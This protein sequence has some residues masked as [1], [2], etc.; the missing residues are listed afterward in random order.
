MDN[1]AISF[2]IRD[3]LAN[4]TNTMGKGIYGEDIH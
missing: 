3:D 2:Q 1:L 4:L